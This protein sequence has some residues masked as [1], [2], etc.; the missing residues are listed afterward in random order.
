MI[1][2]GTIDA[3][4]AMQ[5]LQS[6]QIAVS[7]VITSKNNTLFLTKAFEVRSSVLQLE[8]PPIDAI[9]QPDEMSDKLNE[10]GVQYHNDC[11]CFTC[12]QHKARLGNV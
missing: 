3:I 10:I 6:T 11:I 2:H 9:S 7:E 5:A 12:S 8:E 4:I 1:T